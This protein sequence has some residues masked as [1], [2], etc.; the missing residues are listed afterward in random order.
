MHSVSYRV[1]RPC[2]GPGLV[3]EA[4]GT[5]PQSCPSSIY[6]IE[7]NSSITSDL[8]VYIP[9]NWYRQVRDGRTEAPPL[10][11]PATPSDFGYEVMLPSLLYFSRGRKSTAILALPVGFEPTTLSLGGTVPSDWREHIGATDGIRTRV[12]RVKAKASCPIDDRRI[13]WQQD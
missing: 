11:Q 2:H 6:F 13:C 7:L 12:P 1:A 3:V 9:F 8:S 10:S 4:W 5:A